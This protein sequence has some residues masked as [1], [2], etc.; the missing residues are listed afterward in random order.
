MENGVGIRTTIYLSGCVHRCKNCHNPETWDFNGGKEFTEDVKTEL[1]SY[2]AL[3]YIDGITFSG[4]DPLCSYD[5]VL[6]LIKEIKDMFPTKTIWVYTGYTLEELISAQKEAILD[7]IDVLVD[8]R[9][10]DELRDIT[11]AFRGSSNQ[12]ILKKGVDF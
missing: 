5:E 11:L 9:Y 7:Y 8:G 1:F 2:L 3:P 12:R 4:G 10:V 6:A